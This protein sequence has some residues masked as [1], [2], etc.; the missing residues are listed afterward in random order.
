MS[1]NDVVKVQGNY[2]ISARKGNITL[3]TGVNTGTV[4][5][6]GNLDVQGLTTTIESVNA[7]I[8]DNIITLNQGESS[9]DHVTLLSSG[10]LIDRGNNASVANAATLLFNDAVGADNY[11]WHASSTAYRGIWEFRA[12]SQGSAIRANGIRIDETS[13]PKV[14][15]TARLNIFGSDNPS[16]VI[17]VSGT[18]NYA[19]HCTDGDD[20][21]NVTYV[22]QQIALGAQTPPNIRQLS[23]LNSKVLLTDDGT[24]LPTVKIN[25]GGPAVQFTFKSS[26]ELRVDGNNSSMSLLDSN[27]TAISTTGTHQSLNLSAFGDDAIKLKNYQIWSAQSYSGAYWA[28]ARMNLDAGETIVYTSSTSA[29]TGGG[30]NLFFVNNNNK[31][32]EQGNVLPEELVSRR[33]ALVYAIVF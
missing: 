18:T 20:I 17:S 7:T 21:P 19:S 33:R 11:S 4:Y 26:G 27:I 5:I 31:T 15:G 29:V 8:K 9:P 13:A 14:N 23:Q 6:T 2:I 16:A 30:T 1:I 28:A 10:L 12:G 3:D 22:L 25:L 24:N 32:D